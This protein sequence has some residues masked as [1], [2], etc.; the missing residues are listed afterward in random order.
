[1]YEPLGKMTTP[2]NPHHSI[3]HPRCRSALQPLLHNDATPG[4]NIPIP[5]RVI[6]E[7]NM[8]DC[9][10]VAHV[11]LRTREFK[12]THSQPVDT[13]SQSSETAE[14]FYTLRAT[15]NTFVETLDAF[16]VICDEFA[17]Q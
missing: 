15:F 6:N 1:M 14:I 12:V 16:A 4:R 8:G 17:A 2:P 5:I 9:D 13:C 7:C 11:T 10:G 3:S